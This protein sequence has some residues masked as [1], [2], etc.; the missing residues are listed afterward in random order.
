MVKL[1]LGISADSARLRGKKGTHREEE[2]TETKADCT[3]MR[4]HYFPRTSAALS[5]CVEGKPDFTPL[6]IKVARG[7]EL[8]MQSAAAT[9]GPSL[10]GTPEGQR[11]FRVCVRNWSLK[12]VPARGPDT[13]SLLD[14]PGSLRGPGTSALHPA[15]ALLP[16]PT[17]CH[18]GRQLLSPR[19]PA[20]WELTWVDPCLP[21]RCG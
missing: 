9:A 17:P 5:L 10:L 4:S 19:W 1:L 7:G 14:P 12:C 3:L 6:K 13:K 15:R 16:S 2:R 21:L 8:K 20:A 11:L 18:T